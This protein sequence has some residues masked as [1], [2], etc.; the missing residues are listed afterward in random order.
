MAVPRGMSTDSRSRD[1]RKE[2]VRTLSL[3]GL[4]ASEI[5]PKVGVSIRTVQRYRGELIREGRLRIELLPSVTRM[6]AAGVAWRRGP[7]Q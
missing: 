1:G 6:G 2:S 4:Y 7:A 3:R 5:A